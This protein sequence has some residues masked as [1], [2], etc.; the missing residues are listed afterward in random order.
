MTYPDIQHEGKLYK[1][2][3]AQANVLYFKSDDGST[4]SMVKLIYQEMQQQQ[5]PAPNPK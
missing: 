1:F 3:Y 2:Q 5:K 4:T